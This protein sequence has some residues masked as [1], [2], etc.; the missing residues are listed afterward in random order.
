MTDSPSPP[1]A[2]TN[3]APNDLSYQFSTRAII[4][5]MAAVAVAAAVVGPVARRLDRVQALGICAYLVS[6]I[7]FATLIVVISGWKRRKM[8]KEA[9]GMRFAFFYRRWRQLPI[10]F[11]TLAFLY[12]AT[13]VISIYSRG[14]IAT[15]PLPTGQRPPP[16]LPAYFLVLQAAGGGFFLGAGLGLLL[17]R[18]NRVLFRENGV[19]VGWTFVPWEKMSR[20]SWSWKNK[21]LH[22]WGVGTPH[23]ELAVPAGNQDEVDRFLCE[24]ILIAS[25]NAHA[26]HE[27]ANGGRDVVVSV[28]ASDA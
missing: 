7:V 25:T 8:E 13:G 12:T 21:R 20:M 23:F 2:E 16:Q 19:I 27:N 6:V 1:A 3:V 26:S 9:G 18:T 17:A 10:L 14:Y 5:V 4:L 22:L 15:A 28:K 24:R 11:L